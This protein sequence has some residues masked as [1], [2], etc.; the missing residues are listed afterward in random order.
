MPKAKVKPAIRYD[1]VCTQALRSGPAI[2]ELMDYL[3]RGY[4][5]FAVLANPSG[6]EIWLKK[7]LD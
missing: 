3:S 2:G 4:E 1:L 5:P 6:R 7:K